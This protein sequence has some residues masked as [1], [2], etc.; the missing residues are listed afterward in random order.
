MAGRQY[1]LQLHGFARRLTFEVADLH[2]DFAR[3]VAHDDEGTRAVYPFAFTLAVEYRLGADS[4][5]ITLEVANSGNYGNALR[6][7]PA[8]G[9]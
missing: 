7:R 9:L 1:D 3:C 6:L 2:E 8:S 4:L 5:S